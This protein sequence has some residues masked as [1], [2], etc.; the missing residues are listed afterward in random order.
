MTKRHYFGFNEWTLE[1][2]EHKEPK[3]VVHILRFV[4][5]GLAETHKSIDYSIDVYIFKYKLK[6]S[7]E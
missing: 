1:H 6:E 3:D 5:V 4:C 7:V 2:K